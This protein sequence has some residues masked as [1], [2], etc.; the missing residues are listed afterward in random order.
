MR[1]LVALLAAASLQAAS[2]DGFF[3][4]N[5]R[6][7]LVKNCFPCH[8][9][10]QSG[11][12]R[13]DS[14]E[15]LLKGGRSGPAIVP[16]D[17]E[18]SLLIRAI[19]QEHASLKMPPAGKLEEEEIAGLVQWITDG[20]KWPKGAEPLPAYQLT[21]AQKTFW[22]FQPLTQP[23]PPK[24]NSS[25]WSGTAIDRF[26]YARLDAKGFVPAL[27]AGKLVLI[28]RATYDLTGLPPTPAEIDAFLTDQSPQAFEKLV[29]RLLASPAYGERWGRHWLDIARYADTSGCNSDFPIPAAYRYRN[30]VIDAFNRD[31]PYDQ[32]L[33]EQIAGDLLPAATDEDRNR[34][35]VATGY[36]A[37]SRRFGSGNDE[38]HLTI[39]DAID[40]IGKGML[41]LT[42]SC[43]RCHDHKFDPIP[44][45][46]YY[47][48]YGILK[49]T[50]FAFPGTELY[51]HE[52]DFVALGTPAQTAELQKHQQEIF[53]IEKK[54]KELETLRNKGER[55]A[56]EA[57][58]EMNAMQQQIAE[59]LKLAS[60][61]DKAYAV[62]EGTPGNARILRVGDPKSPGPE[63]PRAFLTVLG[64]EPLPKEEQ[65]S[66]RL[67]LAR[68]ITSQSN[69]LVARV[70]VNR[71]WQHHFGKGIVA[72]PSD[73]GFRGSPPT[74]PELLDYLAAKFV[75]SGWSVKAMHRM[76]MLSEAYQ[77]GSTLNPK[78]AGTDARNE[79]LWRFDRRRLDAE[80]IRDAMLAT[81][82]A[83]DPTPATAHPFPP[84]TDWHYT[85][86]KPFIATYGTD[87][88]SVYLV[89]QRIR[90]QP[91]LETFDGPDPNASIAARA[92]ST[93][94]L[95]ALFLM[96]DPFAFEQ[97]DKLAVRV[98]MAFQTDAERVSYAFRL[99]YGRKP[100]P[101]EILVSAE[102]LKKCKAA[103]AQ[104]KL[105]EDQRARAAL[106][107]YMRV[108]YSSDEFCF[109][110]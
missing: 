15:A 64:G 29:D 16:G 18:H 22:S 63:A 12:L 78:A 34:K 55:P 50:R 100:V 87:H 36:L 6:P 103:M 8:T 51:P 46:D 39:D 7:V 53:D 13:V 106:A 96:N 9:S 70:M 27:K 108:L 73:F 26:V 77:M 1:L 83:L 40:N 10:A 80:E 4:V 67:E 90:K 49:S 32:F 85:Q 11:G 48:L 109:L 76:I 31:L 25:R 81:S 79:T 35:I 14:R 23:E 62:S 42:V 21:E 28:R 75:E 17:A 24:V 92:Q 20:A 101:E 66:G 72:T 3:E 94:G 19:Q 37:I 104:T 71:I 57:T 102:Y 65:G 2:A 43:A 74:H 68:W 54:Y 56:A 52:K 58:L 69:P 110:D 59:L 60:K 107:S 30:W 89:Q 82:G 88:R 97:A 44:T 86:H 38:F 93:T 98:G 99:L 105:P 91:F 33:R 41:G 5:V 84:E 47:A 95:Q 45:R 61:V